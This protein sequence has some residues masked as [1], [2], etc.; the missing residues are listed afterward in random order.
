M[1]AAAI[2]L[3]YV[4]MLFGTVAGLVAKYLGT[5]IGLSIAYII[6]DLLDKKYVLY[7]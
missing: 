5:S 1:T 4:A 3:A 6:R 7:V 2:L